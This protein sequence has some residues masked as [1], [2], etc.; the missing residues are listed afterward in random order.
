MAI[1][2][3]LLSFFSAIFECLC[4]A[5]HALATALSTYYMRRGFRVTDYTVSN[6]IIRLF[7]LTLTIKC[8]RAG[9]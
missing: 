9:L 8:A 7:I 4:D 1:S 5:T 2:V 6:D 3:E